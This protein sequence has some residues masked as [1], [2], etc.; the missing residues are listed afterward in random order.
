MEAIKL[1][2]SLEKFL[3]EKGAYEQFINNMIKQ[4]S[5]EDHQSWAD[6]ICEKMGFRC[7]SVAFIWFETEEGLDYWRGIAYEFD[8]IDN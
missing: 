4:Y 6:S 7:F 2:P 8:G 1:K 5:G 3:K